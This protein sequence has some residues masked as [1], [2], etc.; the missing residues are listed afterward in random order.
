MPREFITGWRRT[1]PKRSCRSLADFRRQLFLWKPAAWVAANPDKWPCLACRGRGWNY[2]PTDPPCPIEGNR[3]R[4]TLECAT[5]G[6][7]GCGT[8]KAVAEAYRQLV[9][10]F[11]AEKADYDRLVTVHKAAFKR[12]TV[13]QMQ[14]L[15]ELGI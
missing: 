4:R 9:E 1:E 2:D 6:G 3:S 8:R 15:K 5:C 11:K 7:S 13:K 14:A 10:A 12:L